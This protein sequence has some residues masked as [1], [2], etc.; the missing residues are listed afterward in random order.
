MISYTR[1]NRVCFSRRCSVHLPAI[2]LLVWGSFYPFALISKGNTICIRYPFLPTLVFLILYEP[3]GVFCCNSKIV[4]FL[5]LPVWEAHKLHRIS[6]LKVVYFDRIRI[7]YKVFPRVITFDIMAN[8]RVVYVH[9]FITSSSLFPIKWRILFSS[10]LS[11][12]SSHQFSCLVYGILIEASLISE[13]NN[14]WLEKMKIGVQLDSWTLKAWGGG[15][16]LLGIASF[17]GK[18]KMIHYHHSFFST[19]LFC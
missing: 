10:C 9:R 1:I 4:S 14:F 19:I 3:S 11:I 17:Q 2:L 18:K 8:N 13:Q 5:L 7:M 12:F 16:I 6:I 15:S